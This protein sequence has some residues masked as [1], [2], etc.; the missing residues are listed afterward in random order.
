MKVRDLIKL[1]QDDGRVQVR[2]RGIHRQFKR[3]TKTGTITMSFYLY[4]HEYEIR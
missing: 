4:N 1:L 3:N 2:T